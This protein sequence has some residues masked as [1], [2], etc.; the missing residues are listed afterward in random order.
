MQQQRVALANGLIQRVTEVIGQQIH[1]PLAQADE[2]RRDRR[3]A[4]LL[5]RGDLASS[6]VHGAGRKVCVG[7]RREVRGVPQMHG[8]G[9]W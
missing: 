6:S 1:A 4:Q 2:V 5:Q 7:G 8:A 3:Q 9:R